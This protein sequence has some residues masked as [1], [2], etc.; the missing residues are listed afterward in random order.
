MQRAAGAS[1]IQ[2]GSAGRGAGGPEAQIK[3]YGGTQSGQRMGGG[4]KDKIDLEDKG[5]SVREK[6]SSAA[7]AHRA[8]ARWLTG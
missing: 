6:P 2:Q 3:R 4:P 1:A 5:V 7:G 8:V